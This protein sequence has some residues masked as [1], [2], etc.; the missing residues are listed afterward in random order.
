MNI[1]EVR[2]RL[3]LVE[4]EQEIQG[5]GAFIGSW[6]YNGE[7]ERFLVDAGPQ[8]S[9]RRLLEA[10]RILEIR[11]LDLIF[12]THIHIDHA[13]GTGI[14]VNDFPESKVICHEAGLPHLIDPRK[15]WEG[16][17]KVLG[18]LALKYGEITAVPAE[19]LLSSDRF[20]REG[21]QVI[22][23]PGHAAHHISIV[24]R[25]YLF[26][27]EAGGLYIPQ[28]SK[29]YLRPSTPP[30]FVLEEAVG[31][32][33]RLL[34]V[35]AGREICY[36]HFGI[37]PDAME[38]LRRHRNQL[39]L[40]KDVIAEQMK[41]NGER[42]LDDLVKRSIPVLLERDQ[43]FRPFSDLSRED[44]ARERDFVKNSIQGISEY[45]RDNSK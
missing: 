11:K 4:L 40:W 43:L 6:V 39:Y 7:K 13:G 44:N 28:G 21:F 22:R 38:M 10:L 32:I 37:H 42:N 33:D 26:A 9:A 45:I 25:N 3:Y 17:K 18:D 1:T 31:S 16:S 36:G 19:N 35:A 29:P 15:L 8:V 14:L 12:L 27:G 34:D 20:R 23:T 2:P 5:F 30:K 41:T 24:F